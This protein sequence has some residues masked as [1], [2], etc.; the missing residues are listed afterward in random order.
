MRDADE[1]AE[2]RALQARAYGRD[3][4]LT[5]TEAARLR[6]LEERR[7]VSP[8]DPGE[9]STAEPDAALLA[10]P[11][12]AGLGRDPGARGEDAAPDAAPDAASD[13]APGNASDRHESFSEVPDPAMTDGAERSATPSESLRTALRAHWRVFAIAAVAA[14]VIGL[15]AGWLA[16]GRPG[17]A[18]VELTAQQQEWQDDLISAGVYDPGSIRALAVEEGAVI[19]TATRD[20]RART[21]LILGTGGITQPSCDRTERITDTG[22]Y[23][24]ISVSGEQDQQR[25]ISVQMLLTAAGEPAVAVSTYDY[26]PSMSGVTYANEE[27]TRTA[28]RLVEDGF[29]VNSLWVVGYDGDVP[30][31]TGMQLESQNQCLIYDGSTAEAPTVCADPETLLEQASSLVLNVVDSETGETTHLEMNSNRGPA[32]LVITREGGVVG[33]G[34]D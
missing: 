11:G 17:V 4:A 9:H 26:D 28:E 25:Q 19:W 31:W 1:F 13:T 6:E 2:L 29:E 24:T 14:L 12:I 16:F 33:A 30:V 15:G 32:Y 34:E 22:I 21:C 10:A 7:I 3:A 20:E 27:E 5:E 23:G 18:P 8:A